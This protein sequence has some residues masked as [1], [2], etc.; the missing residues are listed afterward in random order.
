MAVVVVVVATRGLMAT[1]VTRGVVQGVQGAIGVLAGAGT[2]QV[3]VVVVGR[4]GGTAA[5][6]GARTRH[7]HRSRL[8]PTSP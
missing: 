4:G 6:D 8:L 5:M 3:V 1:V 7:R 2:K